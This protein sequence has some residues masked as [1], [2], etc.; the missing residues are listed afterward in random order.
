M[1]WNNSDRVAW[2]AANPEK[3]KA[4]KRL[5]LG[6]RIAKKRQYV[7]EYL[8]SH[9]CMDCGEEDPTVLEFDHVRGTKRFRVSAM[10]VSWCSLDVLI[11]EIT[12]CEVR[13]ANCHRRKHSKD[14]GWYK[15]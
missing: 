7:L 2:D 3:V 6:R 5:N 11:A 1:T 14:Q 8:S 9:S 10:M 15:Q 12:K 13:C 4:Y